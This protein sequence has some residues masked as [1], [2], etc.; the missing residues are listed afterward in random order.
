MISSY[1]CYSLVVVSRFALLQLTMTT[2]RVHA[3]QSSVVHVF[4]TSATPRYVTIQVFNN[5][6]P[7]LVH[8]TLPVRA[9]AAGSVVVSVCR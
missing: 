6:M 2:K 5:E 4:A 1:K 7:G 9:C 8:G 3:V